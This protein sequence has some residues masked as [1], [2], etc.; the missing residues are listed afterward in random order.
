MERDDELH[1]IIEQI[2][3]FVKTVINPILPNARFARSFMNGYSLAQDLNYFSAKLVPD[4]LFKGSDY[5]Y[6][7]DGQFIHYS[8]LQG[9]KAILDSGYLRMSEFG[10]LIDKNELNYGADLFKSNPDFQ[11]DK[12]NIDDLKSNVFS[13]SV[14]E[15]SEN[16]KRDNLMWEI[17]G[18]K[19][20]GIIIEFKLTK[21]DPKFFILGKV[22]YGENA[23]KPLYELKKRSEDYLKGKNK[24]FPNNFPELIVELQSFHKSRIYEG[25]RE[26]RL[27]FKNDLEFSSDTV[28]KDFNS[29]QE[30]KFFNK[31]FLK[32]RHP[33]SCE[34]ENSTE[35]DYSYFDEFPQIEIKNLILG[36]N[37]SVE[38][39]V[40]ITELLSEIK[41]QHNYDFEVF[42]INSEKEIIKMR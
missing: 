2:D 8:S 21:K 6:G 20:K 42:Q 30:V 34:V 14:C 16:T 5:E 15:S 38:N 22:L 18:D 1:Q 11:Y 17:Y 12:I 3:T 9:L 13:L 19:G 4:N 40:A 33:L 35:D 39:K 36:F 25:E 41:L 27:L 29:S 31:L 28:Y 26:V 24:V 32:G 23:K 7:G 10:N 37:I